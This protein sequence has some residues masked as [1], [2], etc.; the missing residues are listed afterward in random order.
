MRSPALASRVM[1]QHP[2]MVA[3]GVLVREVA[4]QVHL[5]LFRKAVEQEEKSPGEVVSRV[6]R[7]AELLLADGLR[8]LAPGTPVLGEEAAS[9]DPRL[10]GLLRRREP[11]WLVD[12]LDG[13]TQFLAGSPDHAI[14]VALVD[15][16]RTVGAVVHQ[17]QHN[18]TYTAEL[19][20][21]TW[22]DGERVQRAAA[23]T[24]DLTLLEGAVLRRFLCNDVRTAV[25]INAWRFGDLTPNSTC[26]G[27]EYPRLLEGDA[28]FLLFWRT[29]PWD[30]AP[31]ALL[32]S[33]AGAVAL[34][35][36]GSDYRPDVDVQGLLA[37]ADRETA[38]AVL[39]G[40]GVCR[41]R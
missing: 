37:A 9:D 19:G 32:L 8:A 29:L 26:A 2:D 1:T 3:V 39:A 31:G 12:P 15:R 13:T 11:V 35:P 23:S 22:R 30:H 21:G 28:D 38:T 17:P 18:H 24:R 4:D 6:D 36:D 14:M 5:P 41:D 10:L 16:G 34:R 20:A 27:V 25:D 33:E 7:E 40:L